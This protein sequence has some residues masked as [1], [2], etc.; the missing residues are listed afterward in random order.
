MATVYKRNSTYWVRLQ[1]QGKEVRRSAHTTTKSVAQQFLAQ[2]LEEHHRLG[3]GGRSGRTYEEGL[4]RF[5]P[6][7]CRT[8]DGAQT[9]TMAVGHLAR[10][11]EIGRQLMQQP[12]LSLLELAISKPYIRRSN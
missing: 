9:M 1:S 11:F 5:T 8:Y 12:T 3:R 10:R 2:L 6:G 4:E 7:L